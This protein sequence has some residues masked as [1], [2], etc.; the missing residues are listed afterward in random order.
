M[1]VGLNPFGLVTDMVCGVFVD[2]LTACNL[3]CCLSV[4]MTS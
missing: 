3:D 1:T 2:H 4:C